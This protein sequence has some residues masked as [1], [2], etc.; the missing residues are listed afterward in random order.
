[1]SL[2][3]SVELC[4]L[5]IDESDFD[6]DLDAALP[7][8]DGDERQRFQKFKV[9]H[10]K[11]CFLQARRMAKTLLAHKLGCSPAEVRFDYNEHG[12]PFLK[13]QSYAAAAEKPLNWH[14]NISHSKSMVVVALSQQIVGVDVEDVD[15]CRS[16][17]DKAEE[18]LNTHVKTMIDSC[19]DVES[20][21]AAFATHWSCMESYVKLYGSAIFNEIR[22][23]EAVLS[24]KLT[25][26][27]RY[28]YQ[29]T[30]F[31]T[32][33]L[34]PNCRVSLATEDHYP[35]IFVSKW[36]SAGLRASE[37]TVEGAVVS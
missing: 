21:A 10:P 24:E 1:M 29:S 26:A 25:M 31:T 4:Y 3:V 13:T 20:Q 9:K 27:E 37:F 32:L 19:S 7:L 15:R 14:F 12:K 8:L 16:M 22:R 23:I 18:F 6:V 17:C 35:T 2:P 33:P 30:R 11:N 28:A 5:S 34:T 36:S